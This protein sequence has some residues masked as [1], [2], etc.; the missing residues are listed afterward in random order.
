MPVPT[1]KKTALHWVLWTTAT[2]A[3]FTNAWFVIFETIV[4][5][6]VLLLNVCGWVIILYLNFFNFKSLFKK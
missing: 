1:V 2:I 4:P 3:V 6:W 5:R